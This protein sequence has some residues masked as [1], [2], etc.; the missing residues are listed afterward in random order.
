VPEPRCDDHIGE[1]YPR[2]C[3]A[4]DQAA[5]DSCRAEQLRACDLHLRL[6]PCPECG[7]TP[8]LSGPVSPRDGS[9]APRG[10]ADPRSRDDGRLAPRF[11]ALAGEGSQNL[12]PRPHRSRRG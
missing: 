5:A 8:A 11:V 6:L 10:P 3:A 2:R 4:C 9:A 12:S 1:P 7:E